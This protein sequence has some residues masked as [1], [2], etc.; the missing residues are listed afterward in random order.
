MEVLSSLSADNNSGSA[1]LL[2][3]PQTANQENLNQTLYPVSY[4]HLGDPLLPVS[5]VSLPYLT[6]DELNMRNMERRA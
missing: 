4:T 5:N 6:T 2:Q 3:D 1:N